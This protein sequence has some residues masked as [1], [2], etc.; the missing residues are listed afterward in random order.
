LGKTSPVMGG[1]GTDIGGAFVGLAL[2]HIQ[3][4]PAGHVRQELVLVQG[5]VALEGES[6]AAAILILLRA[7]RADEMQFAHRVVDRDMAVCDQK[8]PDRRQAES[9]FGIAAIPIGA[10]AFLAQQINVGP[11]D[12]DQRQDQPA[13]QK[14][15][16]SQFDAKLVHRCGMGR[17]IGRPFRPA[18]GQ[19]RRIADSDAG[20][21]YAGLPGKQLDGEIAVEPDFPPGV[22][23]EITS[24]RSAHLVPVQEIKRDDGGHQQRDQGDAGPFEKTAP[25]EAEV[26]EIRDDALTHRFAAPVQLCRMR[27]NRLAISIT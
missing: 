17:G 24:Q 23:G 1:T 26:A 8:A 2:V 18:A 27:H 4:R 9:L 7:H 20:S 25:G 13:P 6:G 14:R 11:V 12:L 3:Q 22:M 21:V 15:H 19:P 16:Q 5:A 10:P